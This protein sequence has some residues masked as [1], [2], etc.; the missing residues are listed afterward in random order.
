M[1]T[2]LRERFDAIS[3]GF[4]NPFLYVGFTT[5]I[6]CV[7]TGWQLGLAAGSALIAVVLA[8]RY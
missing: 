3:G 8:I 1:F 7:H 2:T 5:G 4:I 6:L